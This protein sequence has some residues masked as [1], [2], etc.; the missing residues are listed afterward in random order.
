MGAQGD[1]KASEA[2][3]QQLRFCAQAS[4]E[5]A[6]L[7]RAQVS[8]EEQCV[9]NRWL[10]GPHRFAGMTLVDTLCKLIEINCVVEAD[11]LREQMKVSDKRYWRIKVRALSASNNLTELHAMATHRTSPIGYELVI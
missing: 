8:L 7:L 2:E 4:A 5:E 9:M 10:N 11:K 1:A 3:Q 6:E